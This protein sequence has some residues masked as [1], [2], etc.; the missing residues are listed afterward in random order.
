MKQTSQ[1][2]FLLFAAA[3]TRGRRVF[4]ASF[5]SREDA[6]LAAEKM[7]TTS[8]VSWHVIDDSTSEIVAED[9]GS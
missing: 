4:T 8:D 6:I 1:S 7:K 9:P 2:K 5:D 3:T